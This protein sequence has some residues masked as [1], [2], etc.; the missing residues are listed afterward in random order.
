M[1]EKKSQHF[2][3]QFYLRNFAI[4]EEKRRVRGFNIK[5]NSEIRS[6]SLRRQCA[7]GYF[8]GKDL[9][10]ENFL[11]R[12]EGIFAQVIEQTLS[13]RRNVTDR[14]KYLLR[15]F[16][17]LQY[18]RTDARARE[19][20]SAIGWMNDAL[21]GTVEAEEMKNQ[22]YA[23]SNVE[24]LV[25][26]AY[27]VSDLKVEV[28][29]APKGHYFLTSDNP[30]V[31][32]NKLSSQL[33]FEEGVGFGSVGLCIWLPLSFDVG[34][35]AYDPSVYSFRKSA[36]RGV[37]LSESD[38]CSL[39]E[40]LT[41][42]AQNMLFLSPD[43]Q[44]SHVT[45]LVKACEIERAKPLSNTNYLREGDADSYGQRT[46]SLIRDVK[47]GEP[48]TEAP[49]ESCLVWTSSYQR[50]PKTF[51]SFLKNKSQR[52]TPRI[53]DGKIARRSRNK[54][55]Y[56]EGFEDLEAIGAIERSKP[57]D[58]RPFKPTPIEN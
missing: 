23:S 35:L 33:S 58:E 9:E 19:A 24:H 48:I 41:L 56:T 46:F 32:F 39:N 44:L 2:V 37:V 4:D 25:P 22:N 28:L 49:R 57:F 21:E 29:T 47:T 53:V 20:R 45:N 11:G 51:P 50:R 13:S 8:Y 31:S 30:S 1:A 42:N 10:V 34:I 3:P 36:S 55:Y 16:S 14:Q 54:T 7:K 18:L 38:V 26:L 40:I 17:V 43:V 52:K 6:A 5:T 12:L 27:E 15:F